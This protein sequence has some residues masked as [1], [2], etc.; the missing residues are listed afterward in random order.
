MISHHCH[1]HPGHPKESYSLG[2]QNS[3]LKHC[4]PHSLCLCQVQGQSVVNGM[5]QPSDA[6][7][8]QI[9]SFC[10]HSTQVLWQSTVF[11]VVELTPS[12]RILIQLSVFDGFADSSEHVFTWRFVEQ[13]VLGQMQATGLIS[14]C[15]DNGTSFHINILLYRRGIRIRI[16]FYIWY[17]DRVFESNNGVGR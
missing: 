9:T 14:E 17:V 5:S 3:W 1:V 8:S 4:L 2:P 16:S 13:K 12:R 7:L 10:S 15:C 6:Q 11:T